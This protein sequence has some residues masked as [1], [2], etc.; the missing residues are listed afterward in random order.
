MTPFVEDR[1][2]TRPYGVRYAGLRFFSRMTVV[3]LADGLLMLHSPGPIDG[4]TRAAIDRLGEVG[5]IVAPGSFHH[6]HVA[7]AQVAYPEATT[8][9]CPGV[10]RKQPRL[11]FDGLLGD[12][13]P[14]VWAGEFDQTLVRGTRIMTEVA[15]YHRPS[16]TL[17][18]VDLIENIGDATDGAGLGIKIWWK[19]VFRM[20]NKARPAPEYQ[21]GWFDRTAARRSLERILA[22]DFDRIVLS[23]GD[24]I[25]ASA[26]DVAREAWS[27]V[28]ADE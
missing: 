24:L 14:D 26:R 20:W 13:P 5:H 6:E 8:W 12:T 25:E 7:E 3:R 23:H 16:R 17:L 11:A 19:A 9:I 2:W 10:E 18:L 1:I 28:L 21:L 27:G 4:E 15:L 22:W